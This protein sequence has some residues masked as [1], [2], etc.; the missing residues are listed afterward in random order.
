VRGSLAEL[1]RKEFIQVFRDRA[2]LRMVAFLPIVQLFL[3]GYAAN[4]DLR[5]VRLSVLDLDGSRESRELASAIYTS[6]VFVPGPVPSTTDDPERFLT[7][8]KAEAVVRIPHG[9]AADLASGERAE[10]GI[11]VDGVNASSAGRTQGY[12]EQIVLREAAR[13]VGGAG[14]QGPVFGEVRRLEGETRFF[15]NP[16][17]RSRNYMVPGIVV[18]II[19]II[20]AMLTGVAVVREKEMGTLEQLLVSPLTPAE[21]IAGKTIPFALIA[22]VDLALAT[23]IAVLWFRIP[24]EGSIP[25]LALC[26]LVYL[27]VTLGGGLLASTVSSTQQQAMFTMWFFLVF[28]I[29]L[30]GFFYPIENMPRAI[31]VLTYANPLRY[32]MSMVRG[33]F[34]RGAGLRDLAPDLLRLA[35]IGVFTFAVAVV[36]FRKRVG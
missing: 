7:E 35:A 1:V 36:R 14:A 34:L 32:M 3:F 18:L 10:I 20:S 9:Y 24:L 23:T 6:D 2:L 13:V 31:Q 29:L 17:L 19:T 33:I 22:F 5:N 21:L 4:T 16:D 11:L 28:G 25:L 12:L 15:Y 8:G 27:L 26:A 30:S